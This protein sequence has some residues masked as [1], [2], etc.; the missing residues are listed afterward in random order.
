VKEVRVYRHAASR[1][2]CLVGAAVLGGCAVTP[3]APTVLVL[4]GV[5]KS[6][7]QFQADS[8]NCQQQ[9]LAFVAPQAEAANNQ[10]ATSAVVG[11]AIGAAVGALLGSGYY[12]NGSSAAWGAGTG[13]LV[14][15]SIGAGQS[16]ASS[17]S[18]QQRYDIAFVQC[19][20]Q[21]GHQVPG[22]A[23]A[24]RPV[25]AVRAPPAVPPA[26]TPAPNYPPSNTPAPNFP[27]PNTPAPVGVAPPA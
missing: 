23:A 5:Q 7:P 27:P 24:R 17:Y 26:D 12:Y 14:G 13:L 2:A 3:T 15:S 6:M 11:T 8:T 10:A 20:Y 1:L 21:L 9:A 16:Q 19:M 25:R 22:H 18:L 4:P